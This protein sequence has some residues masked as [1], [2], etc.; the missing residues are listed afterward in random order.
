MNAVLVSGSS[1]VFLQNPLKERNRCK[2]TKKKYNVRTVCLWD[3]N[4]VERE[5]PPVRTGL[6]SASSTFTSLKGDF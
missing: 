4:P 2:D 1:T 5:A 6:S 3:G